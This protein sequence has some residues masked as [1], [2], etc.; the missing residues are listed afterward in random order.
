MH[1]IA[2]WMIQRR[3]IVQN[4]M[5][6]I[7]SVVSAGSS[8]GLLETSFV[9]LGFGGSPRRTAADRLVTIN[10]ASSTDGPSAIVKPH[11]LVQVVYPQGMLRILRA[12]SVKVGAA[13]KH[14]TVRAC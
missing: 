6:K 13:Q 9:N 14:K 1:T 3:R 7:R 10:G 2:D 11:L 12:C 8:A 4:V 5:V